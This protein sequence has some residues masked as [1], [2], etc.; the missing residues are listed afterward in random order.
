[1]V[2]ICGYSSLCDRVGISILV[3]II[4]MISS[5]VSGSL[6]MDAWRRKHRLA[7]DVADIQ[8]SHCRIGRV[9]RAEVEV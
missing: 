6:L 4:S 7:L 2:Q 3:V 1:M 9:I 8:Y 5:S